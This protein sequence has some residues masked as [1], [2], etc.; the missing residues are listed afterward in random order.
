MLEFA[1]DRG[2]VMPRIFAVNHH[3]EIVD[4]FR[5]IMILNQ[6]KDRGEVTNEWYQERLEILT[7][8]YPDEN[9][10]QRLHLTSDYT[11]LG[12]LRFHVYRAVRLRAEALGLRVPIHEDQVLSAVDADGVG[13][14]AGLRS[15]TEAF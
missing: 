5:Q 13:P 10:D 1:R 12:P 9:S 4:R 11:L 15:A 7:R 8:T 3:P 14:R 6:K 2:G